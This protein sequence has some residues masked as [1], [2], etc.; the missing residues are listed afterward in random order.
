MRGLLITLVAMAVCAGLRA[1]TAATAPAPQAQ[2][3]TAEGLVQVFP[4]GGAGWV[5]AQPYQPLQYGDRLRTGE[6]SRATVRLSA[7]TVLRVNELTTLLI[8]AP[9]APGK[10]GTLNL[11]RGMAYMFSRDQ[12]TEMDFRTPLTSGAIRG[13]EFNLAVADDGRTVV[14]LMNGQVALSNPLGQVE[15]SSGEEGIVEAGKAPAKSPMLEAINIIQWCLYYPGILDPDDLELSA[16]EQEEL[17]ASLAAY[18]AGDLLQ[19]VALYPTNRVA[20]SPAEEV[21]RAATILSAGQVEQA[22]S[23]LADLSSGGE[24]AKRA[25]R[26]GAALSEVIAAVKSQPGPRATAPRLA[27][28]WMAESYYLQAQARLPEALQ[29]ARAAVDASPDFGFAWARLAEMELCFGRLD[30]AHIAIDKSLQ[31]SS[32]NAQALALSGFIDLAQG[33]D[34]LA[35][36]SFDQAIAVDGALGN[37][38]LGR[39]LCEIWRGHTTAGR[40]DIQVAAVL[41]PQRAI[42]RSYL[43]KA[44]S[45]AG[46][47]R[48]AIRDLALAQRLDPNDPTAWLYRAL[49]EQKENQINQA[50]RD[51]EKSEKLNDNERL[52]RSKLL[53]D[54]DQAVRNANLA[55]IYQDTGVY[56]WDKDVETSDWGVWDASHAV[57]YDYA[58][59]SAHEFLA[60]N[61]DALRDPSQINLRYETPWFDELMMSDL[62]MPVASGNLSDFSDQRQYA[63][64]FDQNHFGA[65]SDTEYLSRGDWLERASQYGNYDDAAYAVDEEYGSQNGWRVNNDLQ[66]NTVSAK[67][68]LQLTP[69]DSIF[70]E[71]IDYAS[72]SGDVSQYYN[73]Y[74]NA[75]GPAPD[76]TLRAREWEQPDMFLGY[77]HE[78]APGVHTLFLGGYLNDTLDYKSSQAQDFYTEYFAGNNMMLDQPFMT[79]FD[80]HFNAL[81]AEAQQIYQTE[82][83]TFVAGARYQNG[84][85]TASSDEVINNPLVGPTPIDQVSYQLTLQRYNFYGYETVNLF[86]QLQLTAGVA[87]DN[88]R[89]PANVE[90]APISSAESSIDQVS[91]KA[92]FIWTITPETFFRFAY[93][94]SL[95]G[96]S[97]DNSVRI[98]PT[99]VAGFNQA[100]RS[101]IPESVAG[102]VPGSRFTTYGVALDRSFK[103]NTYA[104]IEGQILDSEGTRSVGVFTNAYPIPLFPPFV[105]LTD[106][107]D[108]ANNVP[109]TLH[110]TEQSLTASLTQLLGNDWSVGAR[111]ELSHAE[112][113][114]YFPGLPYS[115]DVSARL[116]Q[117][118]MYL[119]F[120]HPSGFFGQL[121][122]LWTGQVN[123]DYSPSLPGDDFW[124]FSAYAGY[125]FWHRA[126]EVKVGVLNI[127]NQDY[128]LNPLNF[129]YDLPRSRTFAASMKFYF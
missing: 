39:G 69:E 95:G 34:R 21:Y 53:L 87:Y 111:Y 29:A 119:N 109:E 85:I 117:L 79:V 84:W 112:L 6:R 36:V 123:H 121:Q 9:S 18:R 19:A 83:Q 110:Y 27:T 3:L 33:R 52:F 92:G 88:L 49:V 62:L 77:N 60:D 65:S 90:N 89:Y 64:L 78:W 54:Q 43:G 73:E 25:A 127:A 122:A 82:H 44:F 61:Y 41:E 108:A 7:L 55:R 70:F 50:V 100:F 68:K 16:Q 37:A 103:S 116:Q 75:A 63:R 2:L 28:E 93:T 106:L 30:Q 38:W 48:R 107:P 57:T 20:G 45:A 96:L 42:L 32:R 59:F 126:A 24:Q 8:Q 94:R 114:Q 66:E 67:F 128:L 22:R 115:Q 58:N 99:E 4:L 40:D 56:T 91:P 26:L 104:T 15:L 72:M 17:S 1:Q 46:D 120:Y 97:Y 14:S 124:Q 101:I 47:N 118:E 74:G 86:D 113:D 129:Y 51:L 125:R 5:P 10:S 105:Y 12:P 81:S 98:E 102:I 76:P 35:R 80:R 23:M 31:L 13:T 11:Q 71:T